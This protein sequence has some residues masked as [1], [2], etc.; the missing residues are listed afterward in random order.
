MQEETKGYNFGS[1]KN[2]IATDAKIVYSPSQI[3]KIFTLWSSRC[4][5]G[6]NESDQEP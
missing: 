4:G 5:T 2:N 1:N 3:K 6:V